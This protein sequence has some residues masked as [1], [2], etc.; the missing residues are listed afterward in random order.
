MCNFIISGFSDEI[1]ENIKIQ[2]E[3]IKELG[4]N[5]FEVRGVNGK[6]IADISTEELQNLKEEMQKYD[7]KVSSI[8]SPIG[9][10]YI[11]DDFENHFEKFKRIVEI[12]KALDAKYIRMFSFYI[13][14]NEDYGKYRDEVL[15]RLSKIIAYAKEQDVILLHENEKDIYGDTAERCVELFKELFS[16]NF[17]A[18]FDPANFVQCGENAKEAFLRLEPYIEY[19]HIKDAKTDGTIVPAGCGDGHLQYILKTLKEKNYDGFLSLEPHLGKFAGLEDLEID[20][21]M[22]KLEDS[23]K[24]TFKLAHDSL[25]AILERI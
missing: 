1:D 18:V 16:S 2:F 23:S 3:A 19:M 12:A 8:G 15:K 11:T 9:K 20:D 13:P 7:V 17:K 21:T 6:N 10:I 4:I 22:L 5:F 24:N 25:K 14:E